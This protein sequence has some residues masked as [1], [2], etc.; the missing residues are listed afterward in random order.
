MT[1]ADDHTAASA[2]QP[3]D[4]RL[5]VAPMMD[6]TDRHYRTLVRQI[7]RHTLLY[8]EMVT[9][10]AVLHG[11]RER[12]LG[13]DAVEHPLAL[14]LGGSDRDELARSAEIAQAW[15]YDEVNLNV[16]CPSDRVQTGRFGACLLKEP[17]T[18]AA[19]CAAMRR[20]CDLPVTVKTRIGVDE[21]DS[22]DHLLAFVDRVAAAGVTSFTLH[23]RKAWLQGLSPK[24]NREV[25]PL[26]YARVR[27]L[28][29]DRPELEIVLN[30]GL[31]T[32]EAARAEIDAGV[33]GAMIGRAAYGDPWMLADA[34][35]WL[36]GTPAPCADRRQVVDAMVAYARRM[37]AA[38][39]QV[40]RVAQHMLGLASGLPGARHFRRYLSEHTRA[41]DAPPERIAEAW[42]LVEAACARADAKRAAA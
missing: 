19:A 30:G 31:P 35:P 7:S 40:K 38:D 20:A 32:L 37:Q 18:V 8:S 29:A 26:D 41:D 13:F 4:R 22:Y 3:L 6:C 2:P 1:R 11:P 16:G 36:A 28:K 10:G 14:Q 42:D 9:T 24:E 21:L 34:D 27:R 39:V 5:S 17:E 25:P 23:A 33:D 15:G 12:L